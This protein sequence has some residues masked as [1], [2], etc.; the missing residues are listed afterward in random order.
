MLLLLLFYSESQWL[1]HV[2]CLTNSL[3]ACSAYSQEVVTLL[4]HHLYLLHELKC[5]SFEPGVVLPSEIECVTTSVRGCVGIVAQFESALSRQFSD[6]DLGCQWVIHPHVQHH[7][8]IECF[9][10]F[11]IFHTIFR[12][13]VEGLACASS[14]NVQCSIA[15]VDF[16]V[17]ANFR[18]AWVSAQ[19]SNTLCYRQCD[20]ARVRVCISSLYFE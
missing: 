19:Y 8:L 18:S 17:T 7:V 10:F 14:L 11:N 20:I 13:L 16:E 1:A 12:L 9:F 4:L 15:N 6:L 5:T 3:Y 2:A